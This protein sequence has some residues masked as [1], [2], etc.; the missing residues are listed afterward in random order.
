MA[1]SLASGLLKT[2]REDSGLNQSKA[3]QLLGVSQP[4]YSD[5]ENGRKT[6]RTVVAIRVAE[7]TSNAVPVSSWAQPPLDEATDPDDEATG[8]HEKADASASEHTPN[9]SN[10]EAS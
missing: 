3:A 4:S 5:Y 10:R 1:L 8:A 6:P 2:W 7:V 9:P